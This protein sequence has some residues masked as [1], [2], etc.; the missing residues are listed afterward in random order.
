MNMLALTFILYAYT[1]SIKNV[2]ENNDFTNALVQVQGNHNQAGLLCI[3][4]AIKFFN[5]V[6]YKAVT[7]RRTG[8][9]SWKDNS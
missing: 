3:Q 2:V 7:P 4:N 8:I 5:E 1:Q 6:V 9:L